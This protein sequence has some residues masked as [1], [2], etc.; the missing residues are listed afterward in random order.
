MG[1]NGVKI[2]LEQDFKSKFI[3]RIHSLIETNKKTMYTSSFNS[4]RSY[5]NFINSYFGDYYDETIKS[6]ITKIIIDLE[7]VSPGTSDLFLDILVNY[8]NSNK[9]IAAYFEKNFEKELLRLNKDD[10]N[11]FI[12]RIDNLDSQRIIKRVLEVIEY[13]DQIFID[14]SVRDLTLIKKTNQLF[15]N[16]NFDKDFLIPYDNKWERAHFKFII[17][18]G[19]IDSIGAIHHL[20]HKASEDKE[21]YVIFCKGM[22][23]EVKHTIMH[24]LQRRTIDVLPI[25][26]EINEEN[27]NV[28]N[29]IAACLNSDIISAL[30]GDV[31][32][33]EVRRDL[34]IGEKIKINTKGFYLKC[35][36]KEKIKKQL[37]YLKNKINSINQANPNFK[38]IEQRIKT[39]ESKKIE[40][41]LPKNTNNEIRID[42]DYFLKLIKNSNFG[43]VKVKNDSN[44]EHVRSFY[45]LSE[46][47]IVFK[48]F[49]SLVNTIDRLGC[50]VC[51]DVQ[52]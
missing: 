37:I 34:K 40:I 38:Y 50:I 15:F 43:I 18:D 9:S 16:I 44:K 13:D 49:K 5:L 39:L 6:I 25:S 21:P 31:I 45:S 1:S 8:Y 27:V 42:L 32:S 29:D 36:N 51:K 19:Y 26:L 10:L 41:L 46:L 12:E 52:N 7:S 35:Q 2:V 17:I 48:K 24:N 4:K 3:S 47:N 30:K 22:R 20:L 28:L 11:K 23:E 33:V 14:D